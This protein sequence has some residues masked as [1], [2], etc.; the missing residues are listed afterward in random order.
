MDRSIHSS[1]ES[2]CDSISPFPPPFLIRDQ[3]RVEQ[4]KAFLLAQAQAYFDEQAHFKTMAGL[5]TFSHPALLDAQKRLRDVLGRAWRLWAV[6][7][8]VDGY[9]RRLH[10]G[11]LSLQILP[12]GNE[13]DRRYRLLQ[14]QTALRPLPPTGPLYSAP[15]MPCVRV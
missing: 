1:L 11:N 2:K 6:R 9:H 3:E 10:F 7:D 12:H 13:C 8:W 14:P 4:G 15:S 5:C